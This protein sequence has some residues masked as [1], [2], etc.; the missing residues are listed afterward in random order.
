MPLASKILM[1]ADTDE[2]SSFYPRS[3]NIFYLHYQ[4][5]ISFA[6]WAFRRNHNDGTANTQPAGAFAILEDSVRLNAS[7][8]PLDIKIYFLEKNERKFILE[9]V[10]GFE[11][12]TRWG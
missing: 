6:I 5:P 2:N 9:N 3:Y 12:S 7:M 10:G 1:N 11:A 4:M 8:T